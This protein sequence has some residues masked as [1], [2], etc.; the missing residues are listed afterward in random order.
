[1]IKETIS[2]PHFFQFAEEVGDIYVLFKI[3]EDRY[4]KI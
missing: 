3:R 4:H 1:M 2:L